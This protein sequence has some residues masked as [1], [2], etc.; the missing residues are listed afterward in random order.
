MRQRTRD[1]DSLDPR[2]KF[3]EIA[4]LFASFGR[5]GVLDGVS[6]GASVYERFNAIAE[7]ARAGGHYHEMKTIDPARLAG[8][9]S[10]TICVDDSGEN[11]WELRREG[12]Q[13]RV[14]CGGEEDADL[15]P[16]DLLGFAYAI[17]VPDLIL[18]AESSVVYETDSLEVAQAALGD[19]T[20][21]GMSGLWC[22]V[23]QP[24]FFQRGDAYALL[25]L[26]GDS[27]IIWVGCHSVAEGEQIRA[28]FVDAGLSVSSP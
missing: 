1:V 12:G 18:N 13:D 2:E 3:S 25:G 23:P 17:L 20:P 6:A 16:V 10:L 26:M 27:P 21:M 19:W 8:G 15:E 7:A 11:W 24:E 5:G 9:E 22:P 14:Y 28:A 4:E